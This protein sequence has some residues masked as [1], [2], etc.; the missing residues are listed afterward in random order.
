MKTATDYTGLSHDILSSW[1][2]AHVWWRRTGCGL[3]LPVDEMSG[4]SA[5]TG[6]KKRLEYR[7]YRWKAI[8]A[9]TV[10]ELNPEVASRCAHLEHRSWTTPT[11]T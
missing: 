5:D 3:T 6:C 2:G 11:T 9:F 7:E 10:N 8:V 1:E 4:I